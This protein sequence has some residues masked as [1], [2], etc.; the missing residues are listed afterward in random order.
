M[1]KDLVVGNKPI[2]ASE[3]VIVARRDGGESKVIE[4]Q[5]DKGLYRSEAEAAG[6]DYETVTAVNKFNGTYIRKIAEEA[7]TAGVSILQENPEA[8]RVLFT[9]PYLADDITVRTSKLEIGV[10]R[11]KS[12]TIPGKGTVHRPGY[13][14]KPI[15]K[16]DTP[17]KSF[18][19]SLT[20]KTS[21]LGLTIDAKAE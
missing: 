17:E 3:M 2:T 4:C 13:D 12:I 11:E 10:D 1:T 9:A 18:K 20:E 21:V 19:D 6:F 5:I 7:V 8:D 14:L 16:Y 15:N